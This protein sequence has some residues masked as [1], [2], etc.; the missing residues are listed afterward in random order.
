MY[1]VSSEPLFGQ[2]PWLINH[3]FRWRFTYVILL[4]DCDNYTDTMPTGSSSCK[5]SSSN[6]WKTLSLRFLTTSQTSNVSREG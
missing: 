4:Y 1:R 5:L 2:G 6:S 3:I